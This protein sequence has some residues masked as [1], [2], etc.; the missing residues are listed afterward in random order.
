MLCLRSLDTE[1]ASIFAQ[2]TT[3]YYRG[4]K[5]MIVLYFNYDDERAEAIET[6]AL[7]R[8][9]KVSLANFL[10]FSPSLVSDAWSGEADRSELQSS[11][12]S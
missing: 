5:L 7:E 6:S 12:K 10:S 8:L 3:F 9:L 11:M 4:T 1:V 2:N